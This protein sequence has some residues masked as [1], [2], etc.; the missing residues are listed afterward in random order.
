MTSLKHYAS[1]L[2]SIFPHIASRIALQRKTLP[3]FTTH[4]L[5]DFHQSLTIMASS[6][7][8]PVSEYTQTVG[9]L[10]RALQEKQRFLDI[11]YQRIRVLEEERDVADER[12]YEM[13]Q[14]RNRAVVFSQH[15][16]ANIEAA[17]ARTKAAEAEAEDD[18]R[19]RAETISRAAKL[20]EIFEASE[21]QI[22][23]LRDCVKN[24]RDHLEDIFDAED[25][26]REENDQLRQEIDEIECTAQLD[27]DSLKETCRVEVIKEYER[28]RLEGIQAERDRVRQQAD[29]NQQ[30]REG[31]PRLL[32]LWKRSEFFD[33]IRQKSSLT[34]K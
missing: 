3:Q 30:M 20:Q 17:D 5:T 19:R 12:A 21:R 18:R 15:A 7:T 26:V 27:Y 6:S 34:S 11:A 9:D 13:E 10:T 31:T 23:R 1:L 28:G 2:A 32:R 4:S 33:L 8:Q 25:F 14:E 24:Q 29:F 22:A 16:Q